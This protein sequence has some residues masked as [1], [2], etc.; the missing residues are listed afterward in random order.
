MTLNEFRPLLLSKS[1]GRTQL[2]DN[3]D[4]KQRIFAGLKLIA[5]ETV[6]LRL[7]VSNPTGYTIL[8]S[9][10]ENMY[11]RMPSIP[12]S[13]DSE[14]DMDLALMDAL[15]YYMMAGLERGNANVHMGMYHGEIDMNNDRLT[16]TY[17]STTTNDS[18]KFRQ[19]P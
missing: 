5:K 9:L 1:V 14:I 6:P 2:P 3:S 11:I 18:C 13:E 19:F 12:T 15:A 4:L 8:R 17:L 16:E 10:D 7:V